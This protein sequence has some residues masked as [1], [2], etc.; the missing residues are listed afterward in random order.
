MSR[1]IRDRRNEASCLL[2]LARI[3]E[4]MGQV[5][6]ARVYGKRAV[7]L[8]Q[9]LEIPEITW[10]ALAFLGDIWTQSDSVQQGLRAYEKAIEVI[11][12][13]RAQIRV[14]SLQTGF[15]ADKMGVY[16]RIIDLLVQQHKPR[17]SFEFAERAKS[18]SFIDLLGNRRINFQAGADSTVLKQGNQI[19]NTIRRWQNLL[20]QLYQKPDITPVLKDS[21][22]RVRTTLDS[23]RTAYRGFLDRLRMDN[24]ELASMVSVEP[25]RAGEIQ[26]SLDDSTALLAYYSLPKKLILWVLRKDTIAVFPVPV[27]SKKLTNL[28]KMFREDL[29]K[30]LPIDDQANR[31]YR[32]LIGPAENLVKPCSLLVLIPHGVLHYLP[33][34]ALRDRD[35]RYL[36]NRFRLTNAPSSTVLKFCLQKGDHFRGKKRIIRK[37]LAVGDPDLGDPRYDLPFAEK[38][39]ESLKRTFSETS[40]LLGKQATETNVKKIIGKFDLVLFSTHGEYDPVNPLFSALRLT[41]DSHNDGRLEAWEIFGLRINAFLVTMSACETGLGKVTRGD[42]V[43]GLSRSFIFAGTPAVVASLWKVDDLT[44]AVIMKRFHRYLHQGL[45]RAQALKEAQ[46]YVRQYI[47]PYPYFWAAFYL[48][49]DP[50]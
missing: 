27:S 37:V 17:K 43:I 33:F 35:G 30:K 40:V 16:G 42:E 45:S 22:S 31:L 21:I 3:F 14:E 4:Q 34:G 5:D 24:P 6:S 9:Q 29:Q 23:L 47:H 41:P 8:S 39:A 44:T 25:F 19:Q 28:V 20:T 1:E 10:R 7:Q 11:E 15:L 50:R 26:S 18:R 46:N 36:L 12:N 48:T 32:Y 2:G 38:E 13:Q 49:G